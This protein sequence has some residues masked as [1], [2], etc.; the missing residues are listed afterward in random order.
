ML[1][2]TPLHPTAS[3]EREANG[4]VSK[5]QIH[6]IKEEITLD[7]RGNTIKTLDKI[8]NV[9]GCTSLNQKL[10]SIEVHS[11]IIVNRVSQY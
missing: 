9:E 5:T 2:K 6:Y 8:N 11:H 10:I 4:N 3:I 7:L 1:K